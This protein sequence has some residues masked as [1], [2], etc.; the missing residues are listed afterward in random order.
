MIN[1]RTY[2]LYRH[3][4][5]SLAGPDSM[6]DDENIDYYADAIVK[7]FFDLNQI[8]LAV[9]AMKIMHIWITITHYLEKTIFFCKESVTEESMMLGA[10]SL[11]TALALWTGT[12]NESHPFGNLWYEMTEKIREKFERSVVNRDLI[13]LISKAR[14]D[15]FLNNHCVD[16][17]D[18]WLR[19]RVLKNEII[20]K[21]TIPMIQYFIDYLANNSS[22][23]VKLYTVTIA[24]LLSGCSQTSKDFLMQN[25]IFEEYDLGM[26]DDFIRHLQSVYTCL[27]ITCEDVGN[28]KSFDLKCTDEPEIQEMVG[29]LPY[30]D[31]REVS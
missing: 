4:F 25:A 26:R 23:F 17:Q 18:A 24:P 5:H 16:D 3:F 20:S 22:D 14:A 8:D 15:Y 10:F 27:G 1:E 12:I 11:D 28:Y 6:F 30:V 13:K 21:M 29:F 19:L 31:V 7:D 9:E 2:N